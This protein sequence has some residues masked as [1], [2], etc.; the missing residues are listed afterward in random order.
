MISFPILN[1]PGQI[2]GLLMGKDVTLV[3]VD[4]QPLK[5]EFKYSQFFPIWGPLGAALGGRLAAVIDF[6]FGYDTLGLKQFFDSGFRNPE[7][8]FNGFFIYDTAVGG[9][10]DV[11]EVQLTG[12]IT[13]SAELNLGIAKAGVGGGI[14]LEINFDL[15]DPNEDGKVRLSEL[16]TNFLNEAI[17]GSPALA[18]LAVFDVTGRIYAKLFAYI[19]F[20]FVSKEFNITP[21]ITLVDFDIPFTRIPTLATELPGGVLQLNIGK[22]ADKRLEG[23]EEDIAEQ[24]FAKSVDGHIEV[25]APQFGVPESKP[26]KYDAS[27]RI[28]VLGGEGNDVIDLS[29]V[30]DPNIV[31]EIDGGAGD[32]IIKLGAGHGVVRGGEGDDVIY[33]SDGDD[34][35]YGDGGSDKIY[36]KGG[37]DV[38]FGDKGKFSEDL[39]VI[40]ASAGITD[41]ADI[42]DAGAGNDLVIGGG[43]ADLIGGDQDPTGANDDGESDGDDVIFGDGVTLTLTGVGQYLSYAG[44]DGVKDTLR[45]QGGN[46]IIFAHGGNDRVWGGKGDD[47]IDGGAG[48]DTILAEDGF[49]Q[50]WGRDGNDTILAGRQDDMVWGGA[51]N[52]DI[53]G[54]DGKDIIHG[55]TGMDVIHGGAGADELYGDEDAD[56][57]F[58]DSEGDLIYGGGDSDT[59][60]AGSGNNFV[61]GDDKDGDDTGAGAADNI[62]GGNDNNRIFGQAGGDIITAGSGNNFILGAEGDD[63]IVAGTGNNVVRGGSGNDRITIA[64]GNNVV[65]GD[66][67][68]FSDGTLALERDNIADADPGDDGNDTITTG[69]GNDRIWGYGGVDDISAGQGNDYVDAGIG[70]DIVR[71]GGGTNEIHGGTG[72]DTLFGGNSAAGLDPAGAN[73]IFGEDGFDVIYGDLGADI[74]LGGADDDTIFGLAGNDRIDGGEDD[75]LLSG[76][77]GND[78]IIGGIGDDTILGGLGK[79]LIYGGLEDARLAGIDVD[80]PVNFTNPPAWDENELIYPT[81]FV[82]ARITPIALLGQSVDG[83][84]LDNGPSTRDR[85]DLPIEFAD[86]AAN[87]DINIEDMNDIIDGGADTDWIFGGGGVDFLRGGSGD[88]YLDGGINNDEVEGNGGNDVV[89]GGANDDNLRGDWSANAPNPAIRGDEGI[90]QLYGDGGSDYLFGGPTGVDLPASLR[91]DGKVVRTTGQRLFGGDG[92]DFL[93]AWSGVTA[94]AS[95]E[96]LAA[97]YLLRGDELHG[98]SGGD[99]LYGGLRQDT[100]IG[101]SGNDYLHGDYL[102]GPRYAQNAFA[103][104]RG[105]D[106]EIHGGSGEDQAFGGGGNDLIW[107]GGD[108]DWLEGQDGNDTLY[109]G[110]GIDMIVADVSP[111]YQVL[112][113]VIDGHFGNDAEGDVAD[114]NATDILLVLGTPVVNDVIIVGQTAAGR[115]DGRPQGELYFDYNGRD[116]YMPWRKPA[117]ADGTLGT[118]LVEQIRIAGLSGDD[119]I[120]FRRDSGLDNGGRPVEQL[121]LGDL[122]ARSDDYVAVIDGGPGNDILLGSEARD[123]IDGGNGSDVIYGFGGDDRLWGNSGTTG[124]TSERDVIFGGQ[125]DDDLIGGPGENQLFAWSEDPNPIVTQL[126]MLGASTAAGTATAPAVLTGYAPAPARWPLARGHVFRAEHRWRNAGSARRAG[127]RD[128]ELHD[129]DPADRPDQR[130]DRC[131]RA[132]RAGDGGLAAAGEPDLF[133]PGKRAEQQDAQARVAPVRRV[134]RCRGHPPRRQRRPGRRRLPRQRRHEHA[135]AAGGH[136]PRSHARFRRGRRALRRHDRGLPV[137]QRRRGQAVPRRW[138]AV[139][140]ARRRRARGRL[141]EL[142]ARIRPG[143]VRRRDRRRR[144][145]HRRLR[146]RAGCAARQAR[147]DATHQQ[148]RQFQL[149]GA[150]EARLLRRGRERQSDLEPGGDQLR[151]GPGARRGSNADRQVQGRGAG[152]VHQQPDYA[153][154]RTAAGAAERARHARVRPAFARAEHPA[155]GVRFRSHPHRRAG[156]QRP[157]L[158]RSH[159]PEDGLGRRRCGRR[160][161]GHLQRQCDPRRQCRIGQPQRPA[162]IRLSGGRRRRP[163]RQQAADRPDARQSRRHRLVPL[164]ADGRGPG[165]IATDR[166][167]PVRSR[168]DDAGVVPRRRGRRTHRRRRVRR[169]RLGRCDRSRRRQQLAGDGIPLPRRERDPEPAARARPHH[170]QSRRRRLF[171]VRPDRDRQRG[172]CH[173]AAEGPGRGPAHARV[174]RCR[175]QRAGRSGR[176]R[177]ARA[178]ARSGRPGRR[179]L[180]PARVRAFRARPATS[181]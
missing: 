121:F 151:P 50:V 94:A 69:A 22:F 123:R 88:D 45:G 119:R 108:T 74:L 2:F 28:L 43:G 169:R 136:G 116:I 139:R 168:R 163:R 38:V 52:D 15:H 17:Y 39:L 63:V 87:L 13:A 37:N 115:S 29:G 166:E 106:D 6:A 129:I 152:P 32:D 176:E 118:P 59:I 145:H 102:A 49:D 130:E 71:G 58:G 54:E 98:G 128:D 53:Q 148:Q 177:A 92:I 56:T 65:V 27:T 111:L 26:Q 89:R 133:H 5:F 91:D 61:W 19:E 1:D 81:D 95:P 103:D 93:Y 33:G 142:R 164:H 155:A 114:D 153:H 60:D 66:G 147:R 96:E 82:P 4:P 40:T 23:N 180:L 8:L 154:A 141:E 80:N 24:I 131:Q 160:Q 181:W 100:L 125:G 132:L 99:W 143:V 107:G 79:D 122:I 146:D 21:E 20:L 134:H 9:T 126:H 34:I 109:G 101:D 41:G 68:N 42:I 46:D 124:S 179:H 117:A 51:G 137:R 157:G 112:G 85:A 31:F 161:G 149:C 173:H 76:G 170:R 57:I 90:D 178:L 12:G 14:F 18:P 44:A 140:I 167:Q 83:T 64:G 105:A 3:A 73:Q 62:I 7:L 138:F 55:E 162:G 70:D 156:R 171:P 175:R 72:D 144:H 127:Q 84:A 97:E 47:R 10:T 78:V 135:P 35:I 113:D 77:D 36:A 16:A 67:S 120:E 30:T 174:A 86:I 25:W 48:N 172:R 150:G 75:D 104:T 110:G 165:R 11:P 158:C 159:G